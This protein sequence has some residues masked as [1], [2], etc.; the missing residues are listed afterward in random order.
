MAGGAHRQ[1]RQEDRPGR[2]A[3]RDHPRAAGMKLALDPLKQVRLDDDGHRNRDNFLIGLALARARRGLI[4]LPLADVDR[5]GQDFVDRGNPK[6][7]AAPGTIAIA[8]K[9]FDDFLDTE[10][11][12][13]AVPV[14]IQ[15]ENEPGGLGFDGVDVQLLLDLCSA[16]LGFNEFVA[17]RSRRSVP[18]P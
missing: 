10:R 16:L 9:P 3:R 7:L 6:G 1:A 14:Q 15:L 12:R 13:A 2:N 18:E 8:V 4:E 17:E 11:A 5:V